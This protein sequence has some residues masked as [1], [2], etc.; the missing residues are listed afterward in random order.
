MLGQMI[1]KFQSIGHTQYFQVGLSKH[2]WSPSSSHEWY[3]FFTISQFL[4]LKLI[5]Y[6]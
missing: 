4:I 1:H 2:V 3:H 5:G 6:H